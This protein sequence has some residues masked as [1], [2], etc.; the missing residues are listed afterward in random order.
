MLKKPSDPAY[1]PVSLK[2]ESQREDSL[3]QTL[4]VDLVN[5]KIHMNVI[6][7]SCGQLHIKIQKAI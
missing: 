4:R 1:G 6:S 3:T 2:R 7:T 5:G